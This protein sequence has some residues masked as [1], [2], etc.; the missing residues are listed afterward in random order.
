M[1]EQTPMS[2]IPDRDNLCAALYTS[3][4]KRRIARLFAR[5]GWDIRKSTWTDY[6]GICPFA[7]FEIFA[8]DPI[9]L[10]AAVADLEANV[11]LILAPLREARIMYTVECYDA[12]GNEIS[13]FRR[14]PI[15]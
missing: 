7:E 15:E 3:L 8:E 12:A 14:D 2:E 6:E 10:S 1:R 9:L 4:S 5:R 13:S 11:D